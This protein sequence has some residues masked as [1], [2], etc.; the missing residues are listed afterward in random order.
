MIE[1]C[2]AAAAIIAKSD[3]WMSSEE[4]VVIEHLMRGLAGMPQ[5]DHASA[6]RQFHHF[7][8]TLGEDD[9]TSATAVWQAIRDV[10]HHG[11]MAAMVF[12]CASKIA[13]AD[14][15]IYS[16]EDSLLRMIAKDLGLDP[17]E[18]MPAAP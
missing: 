6:A 12:A 9:G 5:V 14:G 3:G 4:R 16:E 7:V 15:A 11:D 10:A 13:T 2:M 1:A 18:V 17:A 8:E